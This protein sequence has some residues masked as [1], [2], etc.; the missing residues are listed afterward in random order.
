MESQNKTPAP[1]HPSTVLPAV[2][3][4]V[5][6]ILGVDRNGG[7]LAHDELKACKT[8]ADVADLGVALL[9]TWRYQLHPE[10]D[11]V[12]AGHEVDALDRIN[13]RVDW[14]T[15]DAEVYRVT[16]IVFKHRR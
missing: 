5:S 3:R 7:C 6:K 13:G 2:G 10:G 11:D 12:D 14:A 8:V 4:V 15:F 1:V 16:T 9:T